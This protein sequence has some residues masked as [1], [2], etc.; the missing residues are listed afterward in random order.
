[1]KKNKAE[2]FQPSGDTRRV[3]SLGGGRWVRIGDHRGKWHHLSVEK[4]GDTIRALVAEVEA[5][6]P[7]LARRIVDELAEIAPAYAELTEEADGGEG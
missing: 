6:S 4:D 2:V 3:Q 5:D 1:M 7:T